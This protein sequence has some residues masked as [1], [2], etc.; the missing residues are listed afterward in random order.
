MATQRIHRLIRLIV[1]LQAGQAKSAD[2]LAVEVGVS[3]RTVFR[4]L[5]MLE[6]AGV[7]YE[8]DRRKGFS[9][10]KDFFLDAVN[11]TVPETLSLM[12]VSKSVLSR[13]DK[14]MNG[15]AMTGLSKLI[16]TV[17][18]PMREAC[19]ELVDPVTIDAGAQPHSDSGQEYFFV[20]QRYMDEG[21]ACQLSYQSPSEAAPLVCQFHPYALHFATRAWYVF[22][23][24]DVYDE[25]RLLKLARIE[26]LEPLDR[27]FDKPAGFRPADK[28]GQAWSLIPEGKLYDIELHFT[29]RVATNV[30]EIR[31][32]PSQTQEPLP[33]GGARVNF[34]VDGLREI[35][36]WICGYADQV[37]IH[38]PKTLRTVVREMHERAAKMN[39]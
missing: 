6:Q 1:L 4:D 22:G 20:L 24:M 39:T 23:W 13:R 15:A 12:L 9:L 29:P 33:D 2:Q 28:L 37:H 18:E 25:V 3:R 14:S 31:W 34:T 38:K 30:T 16:S 19:R 21:R 35:A 32:H 27:R 17:P 5:R 36:W 10:R 8:H 7:P 11:L 26:K